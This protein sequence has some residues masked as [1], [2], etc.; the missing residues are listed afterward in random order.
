MG[1]AA[2]IQQAGVL[3]ILSASA[4]GLGLLTLLCTLPARRAAY[5]PPA[6]TL[7]HVS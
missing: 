3:N 6:E 1:L 5:T 7:Q 4:A 2:F